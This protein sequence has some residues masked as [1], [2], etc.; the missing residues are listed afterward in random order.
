MRAAW[1]T[2]LLCAE[3]LRAPSRVHSLSRGVGRD[4]GGCCPPPDELISKALG[5]HKCC[6]P[7]LFAA[8]LVGSAPL[9]AGGVGR[10]ACVFTG[11]HVSV[12][13]AGVIA[14][15]N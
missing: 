5:L 4:K 7:T 2:G 9:S 15:F 3:D 8:A 10:L 1:L 11:N 13:T 14:I 6:E 12:V